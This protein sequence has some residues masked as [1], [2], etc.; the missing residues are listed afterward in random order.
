MTTVNSSEVSASGFARFRMR[1]EFIDLLLFLYA[2]VFVRQY[3]WILEWNSVA[4]VISTAVAGLLCVVYV[5]NKQVYGENPK[6]SFWLIT[7]LP[8]LLCYM[9]RV[10]FPDLSFDVLNYHL[11]H[12]ERTLHGTLFQHGDYFPSGMPFNPAGDTVVGISRWFLGYRLGTIINLLAVISAA[13]IVHKLLR[14]LIERDLIRSVCV[15]LIFLSEQILFEI[16]TYLVDLLTLPLMLQATLMILVSRKV[17]RPT[18]NYVQIA[19]L[20]G[21]TA[22]FKLTNLAVVLPLLIICAFQL[23]FSGKTLRESLKRSLAVLALMAGVFLL[24]L[25]PFTVYISRLTGNPVFPVANGFF[26]SPYWP[27]HGGWDSRFGPHTFTESLLWPILIWF[28][29]ERLTELSV[30][31]G[32]L[33]I[34][35][36]VAIVGLVLAWKNER[37]RLICAISITSSLLWSFAATGNGRYGLYQEIL[38]GTAVVALAAA[39]AGKA[40]GFSWRTATTTVLFLVLVVQSY[41]A[42]GFFLR[43]EWGARISLI[44]APK[45]YIKELPLALRDRSLKSYLAPEQQAQFDRVKVWFE[46]APKSTAFEVLLNGSAPII[47]LRQQEFFLTREALKDFAQKVEATSQQDMYSLCLNSQLTDA[48][49]VIVERGLEVGTITP[50]EIPFFSPRT[51]FSMML[52]EIR[53]PQ[54]SEARERFRTNWMRGAF[55]ASDYREEI[56]ALDPPAVMKVGQTTDIHFKV[57]NL[58]GETWTSVGTS[59]FKYQMNMG[60]HWIRN[61]ASTE[62]SRST[63]SADLAPGAETDM[64]LTVKAPQTPGEYILEID[65]VH[66]GVT[67]FKERGAKPLELKVRVE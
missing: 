4:W 64:K 44:D 34:A 45:T 29:P 33:S 63:L 58:G 49:A 15:L 13:Q 30:Y 10:A 23:L 66:E 46:T 12:T 5:F 26:N 20:L 55:V 2:I 36:I 16:S 31:S 14:P 6:P 19:L 8:L 40:V 60:N 7:A 65:M 22:A 18:V 43:T 51:R 21:A 47:A 25:I 67:W 1:V 35:F 27:T 41:F 3:L 54:Q 17:K 50:V 39:I 38:G 11:V 37:V 32:R 61:G 56:R 42:L 24:P 59:D 28:Q 48:K 52:I 53:F 57:R 9:L 62:D